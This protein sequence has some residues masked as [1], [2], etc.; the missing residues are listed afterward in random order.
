MNKQTEKV[1]RYQAARVRLPNI[2][3]T[4]VDRANLDACMV[5]HG[6]A[7]E[8]VKESLAWMLDRRQQKVPEPSRYE[9]GEFTGEQLQSIFVGKDFAERFTFRIDANDLR[10]ALHEYATHIQRSTQK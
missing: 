7:A 9:R 10:Q 5:R 2:T 8:A 3:L 6:T 1:R 4:T